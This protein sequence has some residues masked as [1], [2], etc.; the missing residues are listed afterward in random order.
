MFVFS[1]PCWNLNVDLSLLRLHR[2][3][4]RSRFIPSSNY[5][6]SLSLSLLHHTTWFVFVM[7]V[8]LC[9]I[10]PY[11]W[12]VISHFDT[13]VLNC[14][15][16]AQEM[17]SSS[18]VHCYIKIILDW[19][20]INYFVYLISHTVRHSTF[21]QWFNTKQFSLFIVDLCI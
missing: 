2:L 14:S 5:S 19:K 20:I 12:C 18:A 11:L 1:L 3:A 21:I 8:E 6:C 17:K 15:P 7:F 13:T 16:L 10:I 4:L 9:Y